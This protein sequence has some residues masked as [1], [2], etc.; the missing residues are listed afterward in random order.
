M[1]NSALEQ[2]FYTGFT[3]YKI[4]NTN[5][6]YNITNGDCTKGP[7]VL[8]TFVYFIDVTMLAPSRLVV[9][10]VNV[11]LENSDNYNIYCN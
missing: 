9:Q 4:N 2:C 8:H 3:L 10:F 6:N 11:C 1:V 5:N 7:D